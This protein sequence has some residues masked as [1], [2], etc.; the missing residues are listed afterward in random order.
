MTGKKNAGRPA[1]WKRNAARRDTAKALKALTI[2]ERNRKAREEAVDGKLHGVFLIVRRI[3]KLAC[4]FR[5]DG[6]K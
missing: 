6:V 2:R 4:I 1:A 3:K 5:K